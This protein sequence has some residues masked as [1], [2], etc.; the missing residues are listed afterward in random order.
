MSTYTEGPKNLAGFSGL[1]GLFARHRQRVA[2]NLPGLVDETR[3]VMHK[4][5][6]LLG[7]EFRHI[8]VLQNDIHS[9]SNLNRLKLSEWLVLFERVCPG[10]QIEIGKSTREGIPEAAERLI[11]NGELEGYAKEESC[12][13]TL[14]V[15]WKKPQTL[16]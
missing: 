2:R 13:H 6:V 3:L 9:E 16:N 11:R 12:A 5:E 7:Y 4:M 8:K 14:N 1:V 10:N 15:Y